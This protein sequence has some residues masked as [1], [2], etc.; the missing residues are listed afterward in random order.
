MP[1]PITVNEE[2]QWAFDIA[3]EGNQER[4]EAL[5]QHENLGAFVES[6]FEAQ[7]QDWRAP[8]LGEE[9]DDA[10]TNTLKRYATPADF[11]KAHMEARSQLAKG[12]E[13]PSLPE[14]ATD[15]DKK[16]FRESLGI[17]VEAKGYLEN[18]PDDLVI[19]EEDA[20]IVEGFLETL[21][22]AN[23]DPAVAHT[24]IR[25]YNDFVEKEQEA[26]ADLDNTQFKE[27]EDALR[28][29]WGNEYRANVNIVGALLGSTFGDEAA[30]IL[31]NARG[32]D[33]RALMNNPEIMA[34]LAQM[35]RTVDPLVTIIPNDTKD[36]AQALNDEIASI[37]KFMKEKRSEYNKDENMQARLRE[38]YDI[39][40]KHQ[41]AS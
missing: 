11:G 38:L 17:P 35:A 19:G 41:A 28:E 13:K 27:T 37:E 21:H 4:F 18:L 24:A 33:G 16:A 25:W 7:Q 14:N 10:T 31:R 2:N 20:P 22:E 32:P 36:S 29:A 8:F 9:P 5:A 34:G 39:R 40:T 12:F 1:D 6:H 23:A 30:D 26:M 3:G 15:D